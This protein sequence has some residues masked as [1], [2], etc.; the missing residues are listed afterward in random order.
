VLRLTL[1]LSEG[2]PHAQRAQSTSLFINAFDL[3]LEKR[4]EVHIFHEL[5]F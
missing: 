2:S 5:N 1:A 4:E 3:T